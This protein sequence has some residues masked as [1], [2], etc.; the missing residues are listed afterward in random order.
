MVENKNLKILNKLTKLARFLEDFGTEY[1]ETLSPIMLMQKILKNYGQRLYDLVNDIISIDFN[2]AI[3]NYFEIDTS[4]DIEKQLQNKTVKELS[5][6]KIDCNNVLK[7]LSDATHDSF[8]KKASES[9]NI[10]FEILEKQSEFSKEEI[11]SQ[12]GD[13][14]HLVYALMTTWESLGILVY[15]GEVDLDLIDDFFSGPIKISWQKLNGHVMG[16]RALLE[17]DTIEE[18]FQWLVE[19]LSEKEARTPP[20]PAHVAHKDWPHRG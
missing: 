11:E 4:L 15:R 2:T 19:R 1:Q 7:F 13:D 16:E 20:I 5:D 12:V 17:R 8:Y 10:L 18:W 14:F 6:I 9:L 3:F